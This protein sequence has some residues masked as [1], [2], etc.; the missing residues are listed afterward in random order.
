M[1][2]R[3]PDPAL[4]GPGVSGAL[5][6]TFLDAVFGPVAGSE[7]GPLPEGSGVCGGDAS[8]RTGG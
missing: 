1:L 3:P 7:A 8:I 5:A 2:T 6:H 4:S